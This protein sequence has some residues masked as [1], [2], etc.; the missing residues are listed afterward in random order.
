VRYG[1]WSWRL[2]PLWSFG[3]K[4]LGHGSADDLI[5]GVPIDSELRKEFGEKLADIQ[6]EIYFEATPK[7]LTLPA[8]SERGAFVVHIPQRPRRPHMVES[9]G[10]FYQRGP[11]GSARSMSYVEVRDQMLITEERMRKVRLFRPQLAKYR[12][13]RELRMRQSRTIEKALARFDISSYMPLLADIVVVM[14]HDDRL[15]RDPLDLPNH[16]DQINRNLDFLNQATFL[17]SS[18]SPQATQGILDQLQRF[19]ED[20]QSCE[21]GLL[22]IFGPIA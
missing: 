22:Q 14:P 21:Y 11:G 4:K 18:A 3:Q 1:E 19:I 2:Y 13:L 8:D 17:G 16:V 9:V 7:A 20:C 6:P 15:L 5:I 10:V 12:E